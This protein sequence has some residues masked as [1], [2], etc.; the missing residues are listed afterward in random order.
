VNTKD[1]R[2][3]NDQSIIE[4]LPVDQAQQDE[5]KGGID[6]FTGAL[7]SVSNN[8]TWAGGTTVGTGATLQLQDGITVSE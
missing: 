2:E 7:R 1:N 8:N 4:D 5:V 3:T 6:H